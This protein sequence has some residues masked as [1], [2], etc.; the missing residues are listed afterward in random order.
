MNVVSRADGKGWR[1]L[2]KGEY[3]EEEGV[4]RNDNF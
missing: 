2:K 3:V 4:D 1:G